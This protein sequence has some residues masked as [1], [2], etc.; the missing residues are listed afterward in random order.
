MALADRDWNSR[1]FYSSGSLPKGVKWLLIINCAIF[2]L[3]FFSAGTQYFA[4]FRILGLVPRSFLESFA[5]WQIFTYMFL[6]AP[7]DLTHIL[8][9]MLTL[10]WIGV[11]LE[12]TWGTRRFLRYYILCG[13]GAGA[14]VVLLNYLFGTPDVWTIGASGAIY[15]LLL[16][17]GV[18]F[19]DAQMLFMFLFPMKAKHMVIL[20]G[21]I[22]F[23]LT[24]RATGGGVS[25]VAHLGGL[26]T[27]LILLKSRALPSIDLGGSIRQRYKEWKFQRAKKKFQ[28]YLRKKDHRDPDR[29]VQ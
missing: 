27:G 12:Q 5:L 18:L 2:V 6:H 16:A 28:V 11:S 23:L 26:L 24:F 17:F 15:G 20:L 3:E 8:F 22:S 9:N 10:Y 29:W 7:G 4:P 14:S 21:A 1:S 25:H 13:L 19:P